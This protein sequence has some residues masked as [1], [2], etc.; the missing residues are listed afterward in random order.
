MTIAVRACGGAHVWELYGRF[1]KKNLIQYRYT[2]VQIS[3]K[4]QMHLT[5]FSE[6]PSRPTHTP[7]KRSAPLSAPLAEFLKIN[8]DGSFSPYCSDVGGS[9]VSWMCLGCWYGRVQSWRKLFSVA[10]TWQDM[11]S[12]SEKQSL[13]F[14]DKSREAKFIVLIPVSLSLR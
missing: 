12:S 14:F 5:E 6:H 3:S 4:C 8:I 11:V 2:T 9:S 10:C 13:F 7:S 1:L